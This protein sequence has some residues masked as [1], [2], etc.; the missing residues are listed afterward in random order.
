MSLK[1][2]MHLSQLPRLIILDVAGNRVC[3]E[4]DFRLYAVYHLKRLKVCVAMR[5]FRDQ[6][7]VLNSKSVEQSEL[8][9]AREKYHGRLTEELLVE[10]V[11]HEMF[12]RMCALLHGLT[13]AS[14]SGSLDI[15][16]PKASR[17]R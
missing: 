4:K 10:A 16:Y 6:D 7:Q 5:V 9:A 13:V 14:R 12:D 17:H 3:S 2:L 8:Q 11:G 1:E 15:G